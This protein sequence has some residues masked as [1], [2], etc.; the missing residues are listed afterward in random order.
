MVSPRTVCQRTPF[1]CG[2]CGSGRTGWQRRKA[3]QRGQSGRRILDEPQGPDRSGAERSLL[4]PI[5]FS[6]RNFSNRNQE[7][8]AATFTEY[9]RVVISN[10]SEHADLAPVVFEHSIHRSIFT[11]R[12]CHVDIGI[13][14]KA[15]GTG[16]HAAVIS[17]HS[18]RL[19]ATMAK[20]LWMARPCFGLFQPAEPADPQRCERCHSLGKKVVSDFDSSPSVSRFPRSASETASIG[21]NGKS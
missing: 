14:M 5:A 17:A 16:I 19:L 3:N 9:G 15:G 12:V 13:A 21:R 6:N 8:A 1:R 20:K 10:Y 4:C 2:S 18:T 7:E 11:C